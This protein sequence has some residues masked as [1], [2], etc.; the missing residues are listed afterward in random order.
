MDTNEGRSRLQDVVSDFDVVMLVTRTRTAMHARP[1]AITSMLDGVGAYLVTDIHSLKVDEIRADPYALLT[2]QTN[3][4][5]ASLQGELTIWIDQ[6]LIESLWKDAWQIWFRQGKSDPN[7][8]ILKF[9]ANEGEYWDNAG[10]QGLK[11][12]YDAAKAYATG[13]RL[14]TDGAQHAKVEL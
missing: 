1:M 5:F 7:I 13:E 2:F 9:T 8:A 12:V 14:K 11:Y 6:Q 10:M 3:R 4:K